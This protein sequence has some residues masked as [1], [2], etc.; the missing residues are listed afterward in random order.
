MPVRVSTGFRIPASIS[1]AHP[2]MASPHSMV[3]ASRPTTAASE[4]VMVTRFPTTATPPD[5]PTRGSVFHREH[6]GDAQDRDVGEQV[7]DAKST[8][9]A[10][11]GTVL[12]PGAIRLADHALAFRLVAN[13]IADLAADH[14]AADARRD[15]RNHQAVLDPG[16]RARRAAGGS[17]AQ[18]RR[19]PEAGRRD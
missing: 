7:R 6:R 11:L 8:H 18:H 1:T 3:V 12:A 4:P 13:P 5:D 19:G 15:A 2:R 10:P 14:E 16:Q 17:P 9:G